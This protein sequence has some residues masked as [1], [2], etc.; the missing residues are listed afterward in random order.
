MLA[1]S[2]AL[3]DAALD[4]RTKAVLTT[5]RNTGH[6]EAHREPVAIDPAR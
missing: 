6:H 2:G 5:P 4:D 3:S 1:G